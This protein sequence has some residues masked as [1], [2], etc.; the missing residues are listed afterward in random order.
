MGRV[1]GAKK[2]AQNAQAGGNEMAKC[3]TMKISK[4]KK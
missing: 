4:A 1:A 3:F 2:G